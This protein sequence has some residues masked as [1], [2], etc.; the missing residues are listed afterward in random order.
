MEEGKG[1]GE[2]QK[3]QSAEERRLHE[4]GGCGNEEDAGWHL[5]IYFLTN[6]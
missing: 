5:I 2:K 6:R 4:G 1:T 3:V